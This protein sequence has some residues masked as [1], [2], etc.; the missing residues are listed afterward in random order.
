MKF[1]FSL[2]SVLKVR[3]HEQ[4]MK[5]QKLAEEMAHKQEIIKLREQI[6]DK[7]SGYL[8]DDDSEQIMNVQQVRQKAAHIQQVHEKMKKL[9]DELGRADLKVSKARKHL[10]D[11]H[12]NLHIIEKVKEFEHAAFKENVD[13]E[14][15]KFMDE[16]ATQSY[17]R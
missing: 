15:Q 1:Q 10:A 12:K 6:K 7:L 2:D 11:A 14:E 3:N 16:I 4:K 17:S 13:R 9:S 5:K 8:Q